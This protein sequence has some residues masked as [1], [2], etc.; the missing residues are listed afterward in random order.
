[1]KVN[2][3]RWIRQDGTKANEI[4]KTVQIKPWLNLH[5]SF[6]MMTY[7]VNSVFK[8]NHQITNQLH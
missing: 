3:Q 7:T 1:M 6:F 4:K 5:D 8:G 2:R